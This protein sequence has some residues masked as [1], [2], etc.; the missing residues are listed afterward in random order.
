MVLCLLLFS[1]LLASQSNEGTDFWLAF[2][3][4]VDSR[5]NTMVVMI[6]S[7]YDT[8][9][10]VSMEGINWSS[11]FS[12]AANEVTIVRLPKEAENL[13]SE[14]LQ[15]LAIHV[16][17]EQDVSVYMHQHSNLRSDASIV[18][19]VN[20]LGKEYYT[21]NYKGFFNMG[22][23]YP[24][25]FV[26]VGI[27]DGTEVKITPASSTV[28]GK[29]GGIP[30]SIVMNRG[31]TYQVQASQV[32]DFTGSHI[33]S[34]K[35][36]AVYSGNAWTEIPANCPN[37]DNLLEIM[38]PV[39][40]WGKQYISVP[41]K[42]RFEKLRVLASENNT[43]V[44]I[45]GSTTNFANLQKGQ[46]YELDVSEAVYISSD[47]PILVAKFF[48]GRTCSSTNSNGDPAMLVLNSIEQTRDSVVM[49]NSALQNIEENFISVIMLTEDAG[50]VQ[51]D[52]TKLSTLGTI[53]VVPGNKKYSYITVRVGSGAHQIFSAGCG[54]IAYAFGFG[55]AESYAYGGG[56]AY[57]SI[58]QNPIVAGGC[59]GEEIQFL[60]GE[61]T[62]RFRYKWTFENGE[63]S[64]K[65]DYKKI[66]NDTGTYQINLELVDRCLSDTSNYNQ[67]I[68]IS[69]RKLLE[70]SDPVDVCQGDKL[71]LT[72]VDIEEVTYSWTGPNGQS[73]KLQE[74]VVD[75]VE[76]SQGGIY[77]VIGDYFGCKSF[78]AE[79]SV[80]VL[81]LP[82]IPLDTLYI[83][84]PRDSFLKLEV[85]T[86]SEYLWSD[87]DVSSFKVFEGVD[88]IGIR[89]QA[90]NGCFDK[91]FI[92]IVTAC[93]PYVLFPNVI[94]L[95]AN[96]ENNIFSPILEDVLSGKLKIYDR[97]GNLLKETSEVLPQWD[98]TFNGKSCV[99]G[100]YTY[101]FDYMGLNQEAKPTS[102]AKSGSIL[103]LD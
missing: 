38:P 11:G 73:G 51:L 12:V 3:E 62:I 14:N 80:T 50:N 81:D 39:E 69:R 37:W 95:S 1:N 15:A 98:G 85:G 29:Q 35:A 103:L 43:A 28:G 74:F 23:Y 61:D 10:T 100:V 25:E 93:A 70:L 4:H 16:V 75:K 60:G 45:V 102:Y 47:K 89:V 79:T 49:Y 87:G 92:D 83:F 58:N 53:L 65:P 72:A 66:Y 32:E 91:K 99:P 34:S 76:K 19:P 71:E 26:I 33:V 30:Y 27:E 17:S 52:N 96:G 41:S 21:M 31:Q 42:L 18:L 8:K 48:P 57:K 9:G 88:H 6:T 56:A 36:I 68:V 13:G 54:V 40:T 63:M 97:W 64:T 94:Q 77:T 55:N 20:V 86:F 78:P 44:S 46:Y 59:A 2:M 84:C 67:N 5:A 82:S 90:E 101:V 22:R 24:S 7:R